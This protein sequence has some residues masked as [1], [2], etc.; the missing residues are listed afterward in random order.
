M[1][2]YNT[3]WAYNS[4]CDAGT[5][6]ANQAGTQTHYVVLDFGAMYQAS[7]G[8]WWMTAFG[9]ADISFPHARDM[10]AEW[11]HGYYVCTGA[12]TTSV[13]Y[14]GEG[15]NDSNS[16]TYI[17]SAAGAKLAGSAQ[18]AFDAGANSW[19]AQGRPIG[20]N[21]FESW[22]NATSLNAAARAWISGYNGTATHRPIVDYGDA[23]GCPQTSV[24]SA[25]SCNAGLNAETI[26]QVAWS[27]AAYPLPEIYATTG[28]NAKQWHYLSKYS[29]INHGS[30]FFFEGVMAQSGAC[31]QVGGCT[32]TDNSPTT[33]WNQLNTE[34][35]SDSATATTPG[36]PT[37]IWHQ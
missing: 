24:P 14:V 19:N 9:G 29:V 33:A 15:T 28:A 34:V 10:V 2:S 26:W 25:T 11:A 5:N 30:R 12:D 13:A 1:T 18:N 3:T 36:A 4:G 20:A 31:S 37:N 22:S 21:D 16:Q 7:D 23:A 32:G 35:N 27:G 8:T 6:D 17:T